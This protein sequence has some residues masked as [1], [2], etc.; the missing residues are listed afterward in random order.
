LATSNRDQR[1]RVKTVRRT[2]GQLEA[3]GYNPRAMSEKQRAGLRASM[4]RFGLVQPPVVNL[5]SPERGWPKGSS[6]TIVGGHQRIAILAED[7]VA[8]V[9]VVLVDLDATEEKALNVALNSQTITGR[10]TEGLGKLLEEIKLGAPDLHSALL[11]P[12]LKG[13]VREADAKAGASLSSLVDPQT[14][15]GAKSR[16]TKPGDLWQLGAHRLVCGDSTSAA[17]VAAAADGALMDLVHTD[18]PYGVEYEGT[19]DKAWEPIAGDALKRDELAGFLRGAFAAAVPVCKEAAAWYVWHPSSTRED[20]AFAMK[21]VG[22]EELQQI[23]W[24]KPTF[25][26]GRADYQWSHELCF[27]AARCGHRPTWY[28]DRAQ[29]TVWRVQARLE[30]ATG[31]VLGPGLV[32]SDGEGHELALMPRPPKRKLRSVRAQPGESIVV[33]AGDGSDT[34]WEVA[35]DPGVPIHPTQKPVALAGRAI[36]NSSPKGGHVLDLFGGSG[37]TLMAAEQLERVAHVVEL[38]PGYCDEIV[39]RW[40]RFTGRKAKRVRGAV[41]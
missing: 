24:A 7:G 36:V 11:M 25:V 26:L 19:A 32:L 38:V 27:Y 6:E 37:S 3:A 40:E 15:A 29:V 8:E 39:E 18:R 22:L 16:G 41:Q 20:F 35:R 23:V 21:A 30:E 13:S 1:G 4:G 31:I 33:S 12:G 10:W 34:V 9:D 17:V 28:G 5:R 2:I 14:A